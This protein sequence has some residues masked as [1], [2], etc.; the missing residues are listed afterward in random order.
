M[1]RPFVLLA[2]MAVLSACGDG[3]PFFDDDGGGTGGTDTDG[4]GLADDVDPDDD[5]DGIPDTREP[6]RD[7]DGLI[8]DRDT[9][10]DND[11][12]VDTLEPDRDDDGIIDDVDTDDDNDGLRDDQEP[13]TDGDGLIDDFDPDDDNDGIP[14]EDEEAPPPAGGFGDTGGAG[15]IPAAVSGNLTQVTYVPGDDTITVTLDSLD[16]T[17]VSATYMRNPDLDVPGYEAYSVQEDPLDRM[18]VGLLARAPDGTSEGGVIADGGQ[19]NRV[20][21]GAFY[22]RV[23][24]YSPYVPTQPDQGLVSYAGTYAGLSNINAPRPGEIL[25]V[26]DGIDGS[27]IP[28]QPARVTGEVF[29]NADFSDNTV[30]GAIYNHRE[31][32]EL[33]GGLPLPDVVLVVTDIASNGSF[34]GDAEN[35]EEVVIGD[36]GGAFGGVGATSV[37]GA[38][39]IEN[40]LDSVDNEI[41]WGTFVLARCGTPG[42]AGPICDLVDPP[43]AP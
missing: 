6:D 19:F 5:N 17:P 38:I 20:F 27:I 24:T 28:G 23:G 41:E 21:G 22:R 42:D 8:D 14:D 18:F 36:Y 10:D 39:R 11:G 25:P 15:Q 35:P 34:A 2:L 30:N 26:P 29:L 33:A 3:Q 12:I 16:T 9:D 7:G 40:Y 31:L 32:A 4:D 1:Q 37:A 43:D 13:D